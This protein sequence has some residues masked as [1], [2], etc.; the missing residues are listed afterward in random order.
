MS[1][2]LFDLTGR[3]ALITGSSQGIGFALAKGLSAAGATIVLNARSADKLAT[4][5]D[6]LRSI[7]ASVD[8]LAFDV[9]DHNQVRVS[10][11]AFEASHGP[12]DI[13]INNAGMQHRGPLDEPVHDPPGF[14]LQQLARMRWCG[15]EEAFNF[16]LRWARITGSRRQMLAPDHGSLR[17]VVINPST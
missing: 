10:V 14:G 8:V 16:L 1:T 12:I 2:A 17:F 3:R 4:A 7:G 5:A 15:F 11:D 13:L 9:T 6:Q